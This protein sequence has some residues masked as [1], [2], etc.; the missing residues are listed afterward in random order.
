MVLDVV[1][2]CGNG[3]APSFNLEIRRHE[4]RVPFMAAI[5]APIPETSGAEKLVPRFGLLTWSV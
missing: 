3:S 1:E 5:S 2:V 4:L